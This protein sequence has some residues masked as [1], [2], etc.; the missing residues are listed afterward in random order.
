MAVIPAVL[1][2][3]MIGMIARRQWANMANGDVGQSVDMREYY[4]RSIQVAGTFG[5]G[6]TVVIEGTI[7]GDNWNVLSNGIGDSLTLTSGGIHF[8]T[9]LVQ[10]IRASVTGG[11]GSTDITA[12]LFL[13]RSK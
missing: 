13:R 11:D 7:D 1:I 8:V 2:P 4:D 5:A 10:F 3:D 12:T 9:E 6:G